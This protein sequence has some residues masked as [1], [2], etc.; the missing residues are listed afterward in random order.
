V[1]VVNWMLRYMPLESVSQSG[2][3][4]DRSCKPPIH[5]LKEHKNT[6]SKDK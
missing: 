4:L 5:T 2:F 3:S 1:A 6:L